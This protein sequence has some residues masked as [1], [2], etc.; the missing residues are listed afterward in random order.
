MM[1]VALLGIPWI[2]LLRKPRF[3]TP[4]DLQARMTLLE[5]GLQSL[6]QAWESDQPSDPAATGIEDPPLPAAA[7]ALVGP[8]AI[9]IGGPRGLAPAALPAQP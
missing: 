8:A 7:V 6:M 9:V 1:W 3:E 5:H 2:A 4:P